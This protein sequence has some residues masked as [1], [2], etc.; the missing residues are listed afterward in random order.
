VLGYGLF[1]MPPASIA[2]RNGML[3]I[4]RALSWDR[5]RHTPGFAA[6]RSRR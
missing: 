1:H 2:A 4:E 3:V 5:G 6:A